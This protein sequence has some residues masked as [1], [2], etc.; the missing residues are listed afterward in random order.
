MVRARIRMVQLRWRMA[1]LEVT[2]GPERLPFFVEWPG[3]GANPELEGAVAPAGNGVVAVEVGGDPDRLR[4]W[5]GL[6]VSTVVPV[7][8]PPGIPGF[9]LDTGGDAIRIGPR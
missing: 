3:R 1:G 7:G 6:D 2:L 8:G 4:Q 5:I 9:S